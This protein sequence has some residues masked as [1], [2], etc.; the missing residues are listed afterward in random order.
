MFEIK[1]CAC[2]RDKVNC[3]PVRL[4]DCGIRPLSL[5][6]SPFHFVTGLNMNV[7]ARN[8][9][10]DDVLHAVRNPAND[11]TRRRPRWLKPSGR[12]QSS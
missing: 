10:I 2:L 5:T 11:A 1:V 3:V 7:A 12:V 8:E 4:R 9:Q 6:V